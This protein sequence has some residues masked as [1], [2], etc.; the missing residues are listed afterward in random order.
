MSY[1]IYRHKDW[2]VLQEDDGTRSAMRRDD[3]ELSGIM[4][5]FSALDTDI[6]YH[7]HVLENG[8]LLNRARELPP[9]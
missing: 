4:P 9:R 1:G 5:A 3:Y 8:G 7:V 6:D 2:V